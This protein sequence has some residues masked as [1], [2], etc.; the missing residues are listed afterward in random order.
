MGSQVTDGLEISEPSIGGSN[1]SE[2][3]VFLFE[4]PPSHHISM[5]FALAKGRLPM[6]FNT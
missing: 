5:R 3:N 2:G 1:D 6:K 4:I